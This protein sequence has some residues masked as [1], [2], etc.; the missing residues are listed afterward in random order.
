MRR[1]LALGAAV[2]TAVGLSAALSA[3]LAA[4]L[5]G[6]CVSTPFGGFCDGAAEADGSFQHCENSGFGIFSYSRCFQACHD[7]VSNLAVPT[8]SDFRT[9]C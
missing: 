5:P 7:P 6:Q 9:P 2:L 8:D 4:A 3:P 1:V